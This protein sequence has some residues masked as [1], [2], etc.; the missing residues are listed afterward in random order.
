MNNMLG[1]NSNTRKLFCKQR[2]AQQQRPDMCNKTVY[3][4]CVLSYR[5]EKPSDGYNVLASLSIALPNTRNYT[6][7]CRK[8][9]KVSLTIVSELNMSMDTSVRRFTFGVLRAPV[10]YVW[11][12]RRMSF[13]TENERRTS[14]PNYR[15]CDSS[16]FASPSSSSLAFPSNISMRTS[17]GM[18][19]TVFLLL[20]SVSRETLQWNDSSPSISG[21]A[22][23][24]RCTIT[25]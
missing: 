22:I 11:K 7:K 9:T 24:R 8:L 23:T 12:W 16:S 6:R 2:T 17:L 1:E 15:N 3:Y 13:I 20:S 18:E 14:S 21:D 4:T 25:Q 19:M 5:A 10:S